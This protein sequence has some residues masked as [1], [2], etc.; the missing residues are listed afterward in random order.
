[1]IYFH[2]K[3][4]PPPTTTTNTKSVA[5]CK[6][7]YPGGRAMFLLKEL[8]KFRLFAIVRKREIMSNN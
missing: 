5:G 2:S 8:S 7:V 1:M 3:I 4:A 6:L